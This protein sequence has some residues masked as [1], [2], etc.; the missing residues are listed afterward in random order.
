MGWLG[1]IGPITITLLILKVSGVP[2]LEKKMEQNPEF[3]EYK[4][5]VSM[6]IPLLP[7]RH[8]NNS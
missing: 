5:R 6:F 7:K 8:E 1:I 3:A 4:R 2:L